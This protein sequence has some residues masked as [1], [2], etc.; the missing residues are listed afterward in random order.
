MTKEI[1]INFEGHNYGGNLEF[2]HNR[3]HHEYQS[4]APLRV[5]CLRAL[6][7]KLDSSGQRTKRKRNITAKAMHT[8]VC[9]F[10]DITPCG[11][12]KFNECFEGTV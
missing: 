5:S 1:S 12:F 9:T 8:N 10:R 3:S 11:P 2:P 7:A 4:G 6:G